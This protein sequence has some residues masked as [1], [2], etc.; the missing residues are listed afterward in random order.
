MGEIILPNEWRPRDYQ[1]PLWH[2]LE[3]GGR[4]IDA[5]YSAFGV[6]DGRYYLAP[7]NRARIW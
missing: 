4:K 2:Y 5:W 3:S 1:L 6:K 7:D